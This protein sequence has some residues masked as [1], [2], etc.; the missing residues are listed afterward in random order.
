MT[1]L[2]YEFTLVWSFLLLSIL[3]TQSILIPEIRQ[4]QSIHILVLPYP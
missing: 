4:T 2:E 1:T 3:I